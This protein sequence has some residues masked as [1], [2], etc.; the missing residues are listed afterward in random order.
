MISAL[1]IVAQIAAWGAAL[2][3]DFTAWSAVATVL[4]VVWLGFMSSTS[5]HNAPGGDIYL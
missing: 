2:W 3:V 1:L 5:S 4:L